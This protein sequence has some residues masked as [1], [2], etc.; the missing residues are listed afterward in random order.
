MDFIFLSRAPR[1]FSRARELA[2]V[3]EKNEK[4]NKTTSVYRLFWRLPCNFLK[5]LSWRISNLVN[6]R[7]L[8]RIHWGIWANQ[9]GEPYF[10]A[11]DYIL[12]H[13]PE[14]KVQ[15]K[16]P[17]GFWRK[18]VSVRK[19]AR[20]L[21]VLFSLLS[22]GL[23]CHSSSEE[24]TKCIDGPYHKDKPSPEGPEYVECHSWRN[25]SC[26][27]ADFTAE[28]QRNRVEVLYNFSWNHC[29]NLS[30]VRFTIR[31]TFWFL[32][33]VLSWRPELT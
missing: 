23:F 2:D 10:I 6:I 21:V 12:I 20:G 29:K 27:T 11:I 14:G 5:S 28:L 25:K 18:V 32:T 17:R 3:F 22:V 30:Q 16:L 24:V 9:N 26:C 7:W 31:E 4:K 13:F 15:S 33:E 8:Q 1:S 19:M